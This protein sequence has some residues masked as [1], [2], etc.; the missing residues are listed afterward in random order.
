MELAITGEM[1]TL[2]IGTQAPNFT[3]RDQDK[4]EISLSDFKGHNTLVVFIPFPFTGICDNEGCQLRDGLGGMD[5]VDAKVVIITVHAIPTN[6]KWAEENG[7]EFP[8]LADYWPHGEVA[9]AY[10]AFNDALGCANR[11]TYVL[12]AEGVVRDVVST[13]SLGT[14]REYELYGKALA[15]I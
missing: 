6:A 5:N 1:M 10:G 3:L 8:V 15:A 7:F 2:A 11:V 13:D 9:K 14:P 4:N 12:D